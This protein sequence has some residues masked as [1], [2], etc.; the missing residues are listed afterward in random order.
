MPNLY[1]LLCGLFCS[2]LIV[3]LFFTKKRVNT[4]ETKLYGFMI[5]SSLVDI[6]LV[7]TE[8]L[9]YYFNYNDFTHIIVLILNKIDLIH[10][11]LWT[12]LLLLYVY[13]IS[14]GET[15]M[16]DKLKKFTLS[17][18]IVCTLIEFFLPMNIINKD[19]IMGITGLAPT[20][21]YLIAI[22]Y[23]LGI[24]FIL[25]LNIKKIF[26]KKYIPLSV[27]TVLLVVAAILRVVNPTLIVIPSILVYIDLIMFN[28]IENPDV[29]M[30]E[31]LNMA[32][33]QAEKANNAKTEFLSNMSHEIRTP[34]NAI[35]G[36]SNLLME[37]TNDEKIKEDAKYI[38]NASKNLL[39]LVNGI[40]DISKIEAGKIEIVNIEYETK[41]VLDSLVRLSESRLGEKPI[42]FKTSFDDAIPKY[43][44]GDASRIR[45]IC[46]HLLTNSIKYTKEEFIEFKVSSVIKGDICRLIISVEDTGIGIKDEGIDK[47]FVKFGKL[48][49]EKNISIEGSGL[50]LAITKK[51]VEM[52]GGKIIV[53]SVYG[54]GSKFTVSIDQH[55]RD[56]SGIKKINVEQQVSIKEY[57]GKKVLV[58]DDNKLNLKVA[59]KV[60]E[61]FKVE[62]STALSGDKGIDLI[63]KNK[64]DLILLM[65]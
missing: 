63:S 36:F 62:V 51:L 10:Y 50:G 4:K 32:K 3:I 39:E 19:G 38:V 24:I 46:I 26:T 37:D 57:P 35:V 33:D 41:E 44:Y 47:L 40:L 29:K 8:L 17:I 30:V 27:L 25:G 12:T 65:I 53:Q 18:D 34:L 56:G 1:F 9:I 13:F 21:V 15:R 60:L 61:P 14:Y 5:L 54:K 31:E 49:L 45:Q 7:I 58:V 28:T 6:V 43:L 23:L 2:V 64:Y 42:T 16:Y 20:F 59:E 55:I 22:I 11:M 52:M 48:D